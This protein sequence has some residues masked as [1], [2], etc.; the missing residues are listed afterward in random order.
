MKFVVS[1][2]EIRAFYNDRLIDTI[3]ATF[4][5]GYFKAGAYTQ[6]NCTNSCDTGNYGQVVIYKLDVSHF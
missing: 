4:T 6:A 1:D 3:P 2:G 5:G